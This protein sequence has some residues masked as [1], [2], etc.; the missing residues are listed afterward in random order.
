[1]KSAS[2]TSRWSAR[3]A[4]SNEFSS[5]IFSPTSI[6][7]RCW[8]FIA[9]GNTGLERSRT[10]CSREQSASSRARSRSGPFLRGFDGVIK[11]T[12]GTMVRLTTSSLPFASR[13]C[14][15]EQTPSKWVLKL[16]KRRT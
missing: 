15:C 2:P 7:Y 6:G 4:T 8:S 9:D 14:N 10:N 3:V 16:S 1:V 12:T 5:G 13:V 11:L